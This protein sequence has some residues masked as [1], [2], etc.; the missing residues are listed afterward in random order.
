M[1]KWRMQR[2]LP[3]YQKD[4][5]NKTNQTEKSFKWKHKFIFQIQPSPSKRIQPHLVLVFSKVQ[6]RTMSNIFIFTSLLTTPQLQK[7]F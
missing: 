7:G 5:N 3:K 4:D 2:S 1:K 6:N